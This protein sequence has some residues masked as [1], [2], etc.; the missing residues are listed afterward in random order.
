MCEL[1][2]LKSICQYTLDECEELDC[3]VPNLN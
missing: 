3:Y 1:C 2:A